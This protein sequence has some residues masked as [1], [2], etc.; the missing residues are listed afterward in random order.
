MCVRVTG[1]PV[2]RVDPPSAETMA[3][4]WIVCVIVA[5]IVVV[6][7]RVDVAAVELTFRM[8]SSVSVVVIG[9]G[10]GCVCSMTGWEL[11]AFQPPVFVPANDVGDETRDSVTV[12]Y[13]VSNSVVVNSGL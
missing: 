13:C 5:P 9:W 6:R 4:G 12:E 10:G 8:T 7:Y 11:V 1:W 2:R 3:D